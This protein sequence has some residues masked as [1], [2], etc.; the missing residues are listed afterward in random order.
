MHNT[1]SAFF[2]RQTVFLTG[3]TGGLGG[4]L[5]FKLALI[6]DTRKIYVLVRGSAAQARKRWAETMPMQIDR[7]LDTKKIQFVVGDVTKKDCGIHLSLIGEM[8]ESVTLV[9]HSAGSIS[10]TDPLM[11][12]IQDNCMP[13]LWLAQLASTFKNLSDFVHISTAYVNSFLPDGVVEEKIYDVGDAESQLAEILATG[14]L[15]QENFPDFPWPYSFAKHL[16]ERLLRSRNPG[17]Y[18]V[19]NALLMFPIFFRVFTNF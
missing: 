2:Q 13:T 18:A 11:K 14:S 6:V 5:L 4:C 19:P 9:I 10:L 15:S 7:I 17:M 12:S 3:G 1:P 8:A 16:T